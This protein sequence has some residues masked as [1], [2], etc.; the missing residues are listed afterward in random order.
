MKNYT[1]FFK[2]VVLTFSLLFI[3]N[4]FSQCTT[5]INSYPYAEG[6]E[7]TLGTWTQDTGDDFDWK[8]LSGDT[9][10]SN[11]GPDNS[12]GGSYYMYT[13]ASNPRSSGDIANLESPCFNIVTATAAQFSFWYHMYGANMGTLYVELSTDNGATFPNIIHTLSG[14][15][16]T[17]NADAW[18]QVNINLAAYLGNTIKIRFRGARGTDYTGDIAIDDVSMTATLS[19]A[20]EI[21]ITGKGLSITDEDTTPSNLDDTD[22]GTSNIGNVIERTFNINNHGTLDLTISSIVLSNTTDFSISGTPFSTPVLPFGSTSVTITFNSL[23]LGTKTSTVTINNN[24]SD[25]TVYNFDIQA[26]AEQNFFDSDGDGVFDN[27]DIDDDNDGILDTIEENS[28]E[29]ANG[30]SVNYK[31]LNET[32]GAGTGRSTIDTNNYTATTSYCY[33]DGTAGTNTTECPSQSS[34]ILDDGEYV[35]VSKITRYPSDP[36]NNENIHGD[37]AWYQGD[38][39]TPGDTEGKMAVFNASFDPGVFYETTITGILSNLPIT[40]SFWAL[41]IMTPGNFSGSILPNITVQFLDLAENEIAT[42]NTEEFGICTSGITDNSCAQAEW[43]EFTTSV[44]LG[45]TNSFIVRFINN[46]PGGG[47][48]DLAIDDIIIAQTLCDTDSDGIADI[49]DLDS[50]NDGIPDVVE[51]GLGDYSDGTATLTGI[52]GWIDNNGN[53]MHDLVEGNITLDTDGD[54]TPNFLDLDSDN[55]TL[56]DVDESG[57]GNTGNPTYQNGDGDITGDGVGD[58]QD[59]DL[60]RLKDENYDNVYEYFADG[61]LD[62]YDYYNGITFASAYGN[63]NQGL[64]NTYYVLDSD[65]DGTPDYMD[66]TSDG[67]TYDISRTLYASLDADNDGDIDGAGTVYPNGQIDDNEGDGILDLFDTEDALFGSPRDLDR[68]LHLYFDGRNDYADD[69]NVI[70]GWEEA[71]IMTWIKIDPSATG[72]QIIAGQDEFYLQLNSDKSVT[73]YA[74]GYTITNGTSLNTNQWVHIAS[75]FSDTDKKFKLFINGLEVSDTTV[76]GALSSDSS[77]FSI[78][79]EPDSNNKYYHGFIDE[80]RV[81]NKA[82]SNDEIHKMVYQEI[83]NNSSVVRGAVI[84]RDVTDFIDSATIPT[85]NWSYLKRYFRMD[86]YKDDIID[87]LSTASIDVGSGAKIYNTKLIDVQTAPLPFVTQTSGSLES[88]V[89]I[90]ANGVNGNDATTYDW[91]IVKVEHDNVTFN[92]DQKHLALFIDELDAGSNPIEFSVLNDSELNVSWY[93]KL[94]G[95]IDLEGESQ[96]IQGYDSDLL[97]GASGKLFRDQ[98]GTADTYT[99]NYWSSPVGISDEG[100]NEYRYTLPQVIKDGT[101]N[102][103]FITSSYN[104]TNTSPIG[105][106]D[107]WIWKFANGANDDYSAWQHARSSGNINAGEGFTMKGPGTGSILTE[108]NYV[109]SGKPNNGNIDISIGAGKDYLVGNPYASAL[110]AYKFIND[111]SSSINGTLYFWEHWGG[112]SHILAEY[113][114]GYH[115]LNLSGVTTAATLGSNDPDVGTGGTPVKTPGNYIPVSQGFFVVADSDGGTINFNNGQRIF[116][117]E[118]SGNS[119][120]LGPN[121]GTSRTNSSDSEI[122]LRAKLRLGF[123]S[124]NTIRRQ[125]LVTADPNATANIDWGY[126]GK[127]NDAQIDDMFWLIENQQFVIQGID[128]INTETVLPLG[129]YTANSGVNSIVL[130]ELENAPSELN[131]Y[132]HDKTLNIYHNLRDRA[133][134]V[135]LPAGEY[136]DRFEITFSNQNTLGINDNIEATKLDVYYTN[137]KKSITLINPLYQEVKSIDIL[138]TLGQVIHRFNNIPKLNHTE[139]KLITLSSGA[140]IIKL[141]TQEG[142]VS[143]KVLVE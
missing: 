82:L 8:N 134:G 96:L 40:Y 44:N 17:S 45:N 21:D 49:F 48:N 43:H 137:A 28:C 120:F 35:V 109:F 14:E 110:D 97:V 50:D 10:S 73:A 129:I 76:S 67:S 22:F 108:Q 126:D 143:K 99:Y 7:N 36:T 12:H 13:E 136:L 122:D 98:Q 5:T 92:S 74:D 138:N 3:V 123:N 114:G 65:S 25:E 118:S 95:S 141:N 16:Q 58:G 41:N 83:E 15:D 84:P 57:V 121:N 106:A 11:T 75:T 88:A 61:I 100:T 119:T 38:D 94:D 53:G 127:N 79:R 19:S 55:D 52:G 85:L 4:A 101:Q 56:F 128:D 107:Y 132:L 60:V 89:N 46:A 2:V 71:T 77:S 115:M 9:P 80:L 103:N 105:L 62:I 117:K 68:K 139:I 116:H 33:E 91:S 47:G 135:T 81:F 70:N 133:Y 59:T 69:T 42:F 113:Q 54:G 31:F 34:W 93:L 131:V 104:G 20:V 90:P 27:I 124:V 39:H 29:V 78:G 32:F 130:D 87:D 66:L 102:I 111:N 86:T 6:F 23:T 112:G 51:A 64:G 24:D 125:L 142:T 63:S 30:N 140:Y 26:E 18:K 72:I 37:L 1:Y